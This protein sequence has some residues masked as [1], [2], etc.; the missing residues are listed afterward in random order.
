MNQT[1][2]VGEENNKKPKKRLSS[3]FW[4]FVIVIATGL[5]YL[6]GV[7]H[8]KVESVIGP[9]FG[10]NAHAGEIDLSSVQETYNNLAANYDGKL[11]TQKLIDGAN[12]GLVSGAGDDYTVYMNAEEATE[13]QKS[14]SGDIG[15]GIGVE[16]SLRNNLVTIISVLDGNPAKDVGLKAGDIILSVNGESTEGWTVSKA[17]G[18]VRGEAGTTVKL[19]IWR[20]N[21]E[22]EFEITRATINNPSVQT[23]LDGDIGIMQISRFDEQTGDLAKTA[24]RALLDKGAKKIILDLRDDGGGYVSAAKTVAGLWLNNKTVV[25]EKTNSIVKTT[26]KTSNS[27]VFEGLPTVVLVNE[28]SASASEIV[29]GALKDYKVASLVGEKTFGKG[30]VQQLIALNDN[31]QLKVT[32]ASWYTPNDTNLNGNGIEPDYQVSITQDEWNQGIDPQMEKA[33]Q[34]LRE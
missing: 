25:T 9:I 7:Y 26:L 4:F 31:A 15:A 34:V 5:G 22:K 10:Y 24:A 2:I 29:A 3:V 11:D 6:A 17:V 19:V 30:S 27:A 32:V 1:E 28:S 20:D 18:V 23:D 33:K 21:T 8:Y 13:Y 16:L 12:K 14:L